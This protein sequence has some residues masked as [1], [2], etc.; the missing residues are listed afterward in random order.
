MAANYPS[1]AIGNK[2]LI[3]TWSQSIYEW[4][5]FEKHVTLNEDFVSKLS[6]HN[7]NE[8]IKQH[9]RKT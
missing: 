4:H 7:I 6:H 1:T 3:F 2:S 5:Q 8:S 9:Q